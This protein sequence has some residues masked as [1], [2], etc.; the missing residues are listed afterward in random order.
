MEH[1]HINTKNNQRIPN[2]STL[3]SAAVTC[4]AVLQPNPSR[5][6]KLDDK[7]FN[8]DETGREIVAAMRSGRLKITG[9]VKHFPSLLRLSRVMSV[10]G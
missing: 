6:D 7:H 9:M 4:K 10:H 8:F 5:V 3:F 2:F 1:R